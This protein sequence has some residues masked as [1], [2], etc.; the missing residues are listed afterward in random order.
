MSS[1]TRRALEGVPQLTQQQIDFWEENGFVIGGRLFDELE[2]DELR[3]HMASVFA[4]RY[5]TGTPPVTVHWRPGDP[6]TKLRVI[7]V[8]WPADLVI[9]RAVLSPEVGTMAAQ[10]TGAE[11]I[12]IFTDA[13]LQKPGIGDREASSGMLGWHQDYNWW[14]YVAPPDLLTARIA[15][16]HETPANGCMQVI[17]GSHRWPPEG[18]AYYDL[19]TDFGVVPDSQMAAGERIAPIQCELEPGQVMWHHCMTMHASPP[20][21]TNSPRRSILVRLMPGDMRYVA[22]EA[23]TGGV[24][25]LLKGGNANDGD[26]WEGEYFPRLWPVAR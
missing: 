12:R 11:S 8:A 13:L 6:E 19:E 17:P 4:G 24:W 15:L 2:V 5:E 3:E 18:K 21:R 16:D 1:G 23:S 22:G 26:L 20:N 10:L 14:R 25:Q 7:D 9:R